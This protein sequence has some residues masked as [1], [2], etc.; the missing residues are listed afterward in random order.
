MRAQA[1]INLKAQWLYETLQARLWDQDQGLTPTDYEL[2]IALSNYRVKSAM[3]VPP[4]RQYRIVHQP[5]REGVGGSPTLPVSE[6]GDEPALVPTP[7]CSSQKPTP[8]KEIS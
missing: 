5:P 1:D 2:L 7:A 3:P 4:G 8:F 6:G